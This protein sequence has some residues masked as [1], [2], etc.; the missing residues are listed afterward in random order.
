MSKQSLKL[1]LIKSTR[2]AITAIVTIVAVIIL[3]WLWIYYQVDPWTRDS[4]VR[5][6]VVKVAPDVSGLV[7]EVYVKENQVVQS[8]QKLFAIDQQRFILALENAEAEIIGNKASLAE[9]IREDVRNR[10]LGNL[11]S[12]E[13]REQTLSRTQQ[14]RANLMQAIANRD[15]ARLNL[16]RSIVVAPMNG[17]VTNFELQPGNYATSGQQAL[18][19]VNPHTLRI[20]GYFEETKLHNIHIGDNAMVYLMGEKKVICG[21]VESIAA[22]IVDRERNQS[23]NELPNINPTFS[24][25]RLAQR[26]PVIITFDSVPEDI[27][28]ISGRT[29]TVKIIGKHRC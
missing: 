14:L 3:W 25:V 22:G 8:G 20:E 7:S 28:L 23:P 4:H 10:K 2:Y 12:T 16:T 13:V 17:I 9:S 18:A 19:M 26:I 24:W 21:Q 11:V 1:F 5:A 27:R 29:A 15:T 6:D